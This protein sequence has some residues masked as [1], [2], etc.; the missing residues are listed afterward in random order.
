MRKDADVRRTLTYEYDVVHVDVGCFDKNLDL[1]RSYGA[2]FKSIPFL[3][4]FA[5][6]GSSLA[7]QNT[8]AFE[9]KE[10]HDP[11]KLVAFLRQHQAA[12]LAAVDVHAAGFAAAKAGQ[13]MVFLHFGAPW[14][15]WCHRLEDWM[16]RP[17]IA[18]LLA[19]D[20][21]AVKIDNDRM[22]G[23]KYLYEAQFAAV[24]S[25]STGIPWFLFSAADGTILA[26]SDAPKG[27]NVGFPYQRDEVAHFADMLGK[28]RMNLTAADVEA[29]AA[30][31][32]ANRQADEA[33]KT[34]KG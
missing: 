3:T 10:G 21:V 29:L 20:F 23:G 18:A 5:A 30:S 22:S 9:L 15:G 12:P 27:G 4:I 34:R 28:V 8:E 32:H 16:A 19:K 7:Q 14:C 2:E 33:K 6:D 11:K 1:A 24:G 26:T 31:L 13:K 17:E 25:K